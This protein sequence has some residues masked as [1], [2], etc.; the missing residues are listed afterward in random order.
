MS[1]YSVQRYITRGTRRE[2]VPEHSA[3]FL[4][5]IEPALDTI[6]LIHVG[7]RG[8]GY[9]WLRSDGGT[10]TT[11]REE[12]RVD[13][14]MVY[15]AA[16][17]PLAESERVSNM[18]R[19]SFTNRRGNPFLF[20]PAAAD[21]RA[22]RVVAPRFGLP[23]VAAATEDFRQQ[24]QHLLSDMGEQQATTRFALA[25]ARELIRLNRE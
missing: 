18:V 9:F 23:N 1:E 16:W 12:I 6:Y 10:W 2:F 5:R 24:M 11:L 21:L 8:R 20:D 15:A 14:N 22:R 25:D 17:V 19:A 13:T 3:V 4:Q 7:I